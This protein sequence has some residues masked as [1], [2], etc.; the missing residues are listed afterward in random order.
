MQCDGIAALCRCDA[1]RCDGVGDATRGG[2]T[3]FRRC[4]T[5]GDVQGHLQG[6]GSPCWHLL[7]SGS[8]RLT[9]L[10]SSILLCVTFSERGCWKLDCHVKSYEVTDSCICSFR[11]Y[12]HRDQIGMRP[13]DVC[14][15]KSPEVA[16]QISAPSRIGSGRW[17]PISPPPPGIPDNPVSPVRPINP[18]NPYH[19]DSGHRYDSMM[20]GWLDGA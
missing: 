20:P 19:A 3:V 7:R 9:P 2:D 14:P 12:V 11:R 5:S 6:L 16:Y 15:G 18:I 8:A 1:T 4:A 10:F 13:L 17:H